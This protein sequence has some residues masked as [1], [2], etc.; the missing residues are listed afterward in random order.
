M[1]QGNSLTPEQR[2]RIVKL[3]GDKVSVV[4]IARYLDIR[5]NTVAR[6]LERAGVK[7][8]QRQVHKPAPADP[9]QPVVPCHATPSEPR[10]F[11]WETGPL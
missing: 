11:S 10:R 1:S 7:G 5:P 3:Y 6:C 8:R 9:V 2:A 4:D